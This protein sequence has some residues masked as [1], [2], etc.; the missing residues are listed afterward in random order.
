MPS[1]TE[2]AIANEAIYSIAK[3]VPQIKYDVEAQRQGVGGNY[4]PADSYQK[5][6]EEKDRMLRILPS[7]GDDPAKQKDNY[8]KDN[9]INI[10]SML[11]SNMSYDR[12]IA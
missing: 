12:K 1:A 10:T 11:Y 9:V 3:V 6:L 5:R 4:D 8:A 7:L 2:S